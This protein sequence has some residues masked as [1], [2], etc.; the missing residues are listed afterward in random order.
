MNGMNVT[1]TFT[2]A[3]DQCDW[4]TSGSSPFWVQKDAWQHLLATH[5]KKGRP[6]EYGSSARA[7]WAD[8]LDYEPGGVA[9]RLHAGIRSFERRGFGD[10]VTLDHDG[11]FSVSSSGGVWSDRRWCITGR[12]SEDLRSVDDVEV[13]VSSADTIAIEVRVDPESEDGEWEYLALPSRG[14]HRFWR[15]LEAATDAAEAVRLVGDQ[16]NDIRAEGT[17]YLP[18]VGAQLPDGMKAG[19]VVQE[20]TTWRD[21][22]SDIEGRIA[23]R[24][25]QMIAVTAMRNRDVDGTWEEADPAG[26][27]DI[28]GGP[29]VTLRKA[30]FAVTLYDNPYGVGSVVGDQELID[31]L[32]IVSRP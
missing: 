5:P 28:H 4:S 11:R 32:A 31:A 13:R 14:G 25:R 12:L 19:L 20:W 3:C 18:V 30:G 8:V 21:V 29:V 16:L 26:Y 24:L 23:R 6:G 2:A 17:I 15:P 27:H 9:K 10:D 1:A 7:G 22:G